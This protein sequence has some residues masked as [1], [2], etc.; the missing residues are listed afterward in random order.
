MPTEASRNAL[1][2]ENE[3][4]IKQLIERGSYHNFGEALNASVELLR[5]RTA[6]LER[7]RESRRQLHEGEYQ[8]YDET[9]LDRLFLELKERAQKRSQEKQVVS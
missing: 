5:Q 6:L 3:A 2:A 8:E 9:G 7:L 4:F 1:S